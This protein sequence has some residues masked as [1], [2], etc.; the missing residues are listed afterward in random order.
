MMVDGP[1]L[2][3]SLVDEVASRTPE[4]RA[5]IFDKLT[6]LYLDRRDTLSSSERQLMFDIL[7]T[8]IADVER[9][10]RYELVESLSKRDDV[11]QSLIVAL[12]NMRIEIAEPI[13][14]NSPVLEDQDLLEVI[15][16]RSQEHLLAVAIR[17]RLSE[18]VTDALVEYG[19]VGVI[20]RLLAN[21]DA[22]I[23]R[24]S[25]ARLVTQSQQH[26]AFCEPLLHREDLPQPLAH[27]IFWWVS[28]ALRSFI[29][30]NYT[31]P[32]QV[33]DAHLVA[34][35][36]NLAAD[37][38]V[39]SI[40]IEA[41]RL[42]ERLEKLDELNERF[43][44]QAL[45]SGRIPVFFAGMA[46]LCRVDLRTMRRII[47]DPS[48]E[49]L[50]IACRAIRFERRTFATIFLLTHHRS[51]GMRPEQFEYVLD[52]FDRLEIARARL[53][54]QYWRDDVDYL[55]AVAPVGDQ[56]NYRQ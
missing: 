14:S 49:P 4:G 48:G 20:D 41:M 52:L 56:K 29:L 37:E 9:T 25:F 38:S 2:L 53:V 28:A 26:H 34:A 16:H 50:A 24:R 12:S 39:A 1:R 27:R 54:L 36:T 42:V 35:V 7:S 3:S 45:R 51:E 5:H 46:L 30:D 11:P 33:V 6:D 18:T 55:Q 43:L 15:R 19:D 13:L 8:L 32:S 22:A 47:F 17:R 23:S 44:V 10:I 40:D 31:V 21:P